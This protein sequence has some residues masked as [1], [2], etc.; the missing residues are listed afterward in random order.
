MV[1]DLKGFQEPEIQFAMSDSRVLSL[2]SERLKQQELKEVSVKHTYLALWTF[3]F[4]RAKSA[5]AS[6]GLCLSCRKLKFASE[7]FLYGSGALFAPTP[8]PPTQW[9][10]H[11]EEVTAKE[12]VQVVQVSWSLDACM[13]ILVLRFQEDR[14]FKET[15]QVAGLQVCQ[16]YG[17]RI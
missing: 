6:F 2:L 12:L 11:L 1:C 16:I 13:R 5:E 10:H 17:L 15:G 9:I 3:V 7:R 4:G 8:I 14:V